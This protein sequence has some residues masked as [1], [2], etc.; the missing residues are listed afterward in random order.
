MVPGLTPPIA[1]IRT[2]I[3]CHRHVLSTMPTKRGFAPLV[4]YCLASSL[5]PGRLRHKFGR[6]IFATTGLCPTGTAA[7]SDRNIA[8][9]STVVPMLRHVRGVNVP[10]LI[11]NRI[12][13]TSVSVFSHRTHFVRDIVRPLHRHLATLGII[14]R[15][16]AAGSTT[17]CIHSKGRQLTTAVAPRR[18]VF[19]HGRVLIN[20]IHPRLCYLPV[21]GHGV[22][23]RTLHRL[24]TDNFGQMFLNAS[25][26]PRTHRHGRDDYNYTNYFGTPATLNDCT[27][28]FRRVGTLRRFRTFYSMGNPRFCNLP[29][30]SAFVRLMHRRRRITR[31]VTLASSALIPFLTK[32]AMH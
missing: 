27:A 25:S 11:R 14:F 13:R 26:T 7:G 16:V 23:R 1:A 17:S 29:I 12:A 10:L 19:G 20:N 18:L 6:N 3:T 21:L 9:V 31:D 5:S 22:R 30:G 32:R 8:S 15:R 24:I 28:I 2:T 4:A